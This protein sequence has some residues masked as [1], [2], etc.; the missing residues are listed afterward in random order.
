MD[1][2]QQIPAG[3]K[4]INFINRDDVVSSI[5]KRDN[6]DS[7]DKIFMVT[8]VTNLT[9]MDFPRQYGKLELER[10]ILKPGGGFHLVTVNLV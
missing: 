4:I 2:F 10:L 5:L 6:M 3:K 9:R 7:L 8:A 1:L